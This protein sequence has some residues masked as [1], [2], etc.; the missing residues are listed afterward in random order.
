MSEEKVEIY[1]DGACKGNPGPGGWGAVLFYK[2]AERELWGG[3]AETTNN[4]MELMAAIMALAALKRHCEVRIVTDSQY[5]MQGITEWMVN[6]KKRGWKTAAK[7][8]VKNADLWQALDEQV[9]RHNV[10]WRWVRG[11]TGHPGNERADMLAN[12]GVSELPR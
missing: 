8:P 3:E 7:Q 6:W 4:R 9:N 12:R 10:E 5:V 1:T 11:H 2:G